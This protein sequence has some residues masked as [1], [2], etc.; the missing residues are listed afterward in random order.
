MMINDIPRLSDDDLLAATRRAAS[1]ERSA[2]VK[3]IALLAEL[4]AR[5]LYLG[6][7]CAS[8]FTYCTTALHLS[9]HAAY[10]RIEAARAARQYP[11][12]LDRLRDG[13]VTLT[14]IGL[15]RPHLTAANHRALLEA[16]RHR[17]KREVERLVAGLAPKEDV[18]PLIR[19]V[20]VV[21]P[22]RIAAAPAVTSTRQPP[23]AA[24][25]ESHAQPA[26]PPAASAPAAAHVESPAT[27]DRYLLRVT[28]GG[29]THAKLQRARDLLRHAIPNGDPAAVIDRALTVLLQQLERKKIAA[30]PR[31]RPSW[32][33]RGTGRHIP[34]AVR[35]TVWTRD[36]ARC[37]FVGPE[38][39][40]AETSRLE[41]H[42]VRPF[43]HGGPTDA[44]NLTLR[45]RAHN[46]FEGRLMFGDRCAS[47]RREVPH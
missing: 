34:A 46:A 9:D 45:C 42:H 23:A 43:A 41:F 37:T 22:L 38:G 31:P 11:V 5:R 27:G 33:I 24:P 8:L 1:D 32:T 12:I 44:D 35:R 7:G 36:G 21:L 2:T 13:A 20:P 4:D 16:A 18:A 40:C 15:L 29:D 6:Q 47:A 3:L 26:A 25:I 17:S 19:R 28:I 10:H 30:T 39:R 14:T